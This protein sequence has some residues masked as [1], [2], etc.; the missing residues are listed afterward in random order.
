MTDD[1]A[2]TVDAIETAIPLALAPLVKRL[3]ELETATADV[4]ALRE[5]IAAL[6]SF[7]QAFDAGAEPPTD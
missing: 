6:E 2:G 4:G 7:K 1:P 5:K 3:R